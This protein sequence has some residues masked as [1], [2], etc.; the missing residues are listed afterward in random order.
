MIHGVTS[1]TAYRVLQGV[2]ASALL[3][4]ISGC[5]TT[6]L[7]P[8]PS[9][10]EIVQMSQEGVAPEQIVQRIRE[11]RAVYRLPASE[12]AKLKS[13]GVADA[14]LDYMQQTYLDD[15]RRRAYYQAGP[16]WGPYGYW[17]GP[18]PLVIV[19]RRR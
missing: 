18:P 15:E 2:L 5:A 9:V 13:R 7:K 16:Y 3:L 4:L 8:P 17:W 12:L 6:P 19:H 1:L 10:A 11:S 14:V